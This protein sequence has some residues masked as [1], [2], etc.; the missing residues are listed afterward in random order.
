MNTHAL[1]TRVI[2]ENTCSLP[3]Y[4]PNTSNS[5]VKK[6]QKAQVAPPEL[7]WLFYKTESK[8]W[9]IMKLILSIQ[10]TYMGLYYV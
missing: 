3:S 1:Y 4:K 6:K 2:E 9:Q 10:L 8:Y 5:A 7:L